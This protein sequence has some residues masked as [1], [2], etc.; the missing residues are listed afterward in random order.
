MPANHRLS[1]FDDGTFGVSAQIGEAVK[2]GEVSLDNTLA[3]TAEALR[4]A[5][6]GCALIESWRGGGQ[7]KDI[8]ASE[9]AKGDASHSSPQNTSAEMAA[10]FRDRCAHRDTRRR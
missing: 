8:L 7:Q 10:V 2:G 1:F 9:F 6:V 5:A 3:I 4:I